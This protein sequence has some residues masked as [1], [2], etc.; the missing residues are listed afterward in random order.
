MPACVNYS[1]IDA[2]VADSLWSIAKMRQNAF[3]G[4]LLRF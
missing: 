1:A 3:A 4:A 2:T